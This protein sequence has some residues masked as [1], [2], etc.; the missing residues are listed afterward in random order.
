MGGGGRG[1]LYIEKARG[2]T[3]GRKVINAGVNEIEKM[4][5]KITFV[6]RQDIRL[7]DYSCMVYSLILLLDIAF[8]IAGRVS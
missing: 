7:E 2:G 3:F 4:R 8:S 5:F 1:C 6:H